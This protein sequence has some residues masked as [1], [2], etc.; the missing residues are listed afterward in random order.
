[1]KNTSFAIRVAL[2]SAVTSVG[3]MVPSA[4]ASDLIFCV[5]KSTRVVTYPSSGKCSSSQLSLSVVSNSI[6][7]PKSHTTTAAI[8]PKSTTLK[9]SVPNVLGMNAAQAKSILEKA[10]FKIAIKGSS[11][12]TVFA[13]V[14]KAG[15]LSTGGS[16]VTL[17][18]K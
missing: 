18:A 17:L 13:T 14:P 8:V 5:S 11:T 15:A 6:N 10:G 4:V 16:V 3:L 12:G 7:L 1:M 2:V 9:I